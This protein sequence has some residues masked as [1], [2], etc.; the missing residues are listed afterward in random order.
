M[1]GPFYL[2]GLAG[3]L[4]ATAGNLWSFRPP[5][6]PTKFYRDR[7]D[8]RVAYNPDDIRR[9][10]PFIDEAYKNGNRMLYDVSAEI[11]MSSELYHTMGW[12]SFVRLAYGFNEIRG[13][14]DVN[15]DDILDTND[16]ALGDELSNETEPA[17]FRLYV[18]LGTGW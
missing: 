13:W 3:Q 9:E 11:R 8:E 15:G 2:I 14:G 18:G 17:G 1:F 4:S 12:D 10:I 16:S 7:Y 5:S 6:D